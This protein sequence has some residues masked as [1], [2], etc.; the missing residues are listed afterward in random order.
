[1]SK[2]LATFDYS[3]IDKDTKG[4]LIWYGAE[5]KKQA[6]RHVEAGLSAGKLLR[7]A[8][9]LCGEKPF[10]DWAPSEAGCSVR[11][12]YNYIS[13]YESFGECANFAH[14]ELSAMY[15]LTK[16]NGAR[17]AALK[18]AAKGTSVTHEMAKELVSQHTKQAEQ[19]SETGE[20]TPAPTG[21]AN[22]GAAGENGNGGGTARGRVSSAP[23]TETD[24]GQ[25][26]NCAGTKWDEDGEGVACAKCSHP[27]GEAVGDIDPDKAAWELAIP[28]VDDFRVRLNSYI[29]SV[30]DAN[31]KPGYELVVKHRARILLDLNNVKGAIVGC[32][33]H[34]ACP[35]C[36][37][38][39]CDTCSN[40]GWMNKTDF[41]N[42]PK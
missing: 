40:R 22:D 16:N 37:G 6:T 20:T 12:A 5:I 25:C 31:E 39:G 18:L 13:A 26:P 21:S 9:E 3:L 7:E 17:K 1:M 29:K 35:Y 30:K 14:I 23:A 15:V 28:D 41:E 4:K 10:R 36:N 34:A 8:R 42:V 32:V 38:E 19:P 24:Y 27:H 11:T 2:S 33:P